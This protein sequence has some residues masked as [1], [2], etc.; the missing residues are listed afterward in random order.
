MYIIYTVKSLFEGVT[1]ETDKETG[2][3]DRRGDVVESGEV[4]EMEIDSE[5]GREQQ[6]KEIQTGKETDVQE[7]GRQQEREVKKIVTDKDVEEGRQAEKGE[8]GEQMTIEE[9]KQR[10][11]VQ[12][13]LGLEWNV[14][15][16]GEIR[17]RE[18]KEIIVVRNVEEAGGTHTHVEEK[19]QTDIKESGAAEKD[20][21]EERGQK[22]EW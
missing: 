17:Q 18:R 4:V 14:E 1:L 7:G 16:K 5:E 3:D 6:E 21:E 11:N 9:N 22:D 13:E 2:Q 19:R 15:A 8:M 10:N 12:T 20:I